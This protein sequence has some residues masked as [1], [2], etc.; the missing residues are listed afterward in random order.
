MSI[1]VSELLVGDESTSSWQFH[2]L[3]GE[4]TVNELHSIANSNRASVKHSA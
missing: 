3:S 2:W 4:M 1:I